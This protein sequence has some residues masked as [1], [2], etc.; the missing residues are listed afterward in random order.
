MLKKKK[1]TLEMRIHSIGNSKVISN[2]NNYY[3]R[4]T[5]AI[6]KPFKGGKSQ[7]ILTSLLVKIILD[8][9]LCVLL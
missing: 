1:K 3:N 6:P 5:Q 2:S 8:S 7:Q 9:Y 4:Q